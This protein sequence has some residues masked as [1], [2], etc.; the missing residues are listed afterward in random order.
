MDLFVVRVLL[1]MSSILVNRQ[2]PYKKFGFHP[3]G[4]KL[5]TISDLLPASVVSLS[6][7]TGKLLRSEIGNITTGYTLSQATTDF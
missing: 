3:A 1:G 5:Q 6:G 2:K 7:V 4:R